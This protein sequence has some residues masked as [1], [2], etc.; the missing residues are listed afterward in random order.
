MN[1][2]I[3]IVPMAEVVVVEVDGTVD[4]MV[5]VEAA[6]DVEVLPML[7]VVRLVV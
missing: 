1:L 4:V 2:I 7:A 5:D 6:E 3:V